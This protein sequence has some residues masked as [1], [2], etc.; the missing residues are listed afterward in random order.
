MGVSFEF[1]VVSDSEKQAQKWLDFAIEETK[2]VED[3]ISSWKPTS[4][5]SKINQNAGIKPVKVSK[6]L[7]DLIKRSKEISKLTRGYF[8][9]S[10][11]SI[12]KIWDFQK[13]YTQIPDSLEVK[14]SVSKI[15]YENIILNNEK[16]T[17]FLKEKG[18][19]IGF[20]AIGKGFV[21]EHIKKLWKKQGVSVGLINASGDLTC[22]G[23]PPQSEAWKIGI[24]NPFDKTHD[25]GWF[26]LKDSGVVTSGGYE[27]YVEINGKRYAHIINPKTGWPS[28]GLASVTIFCANAELADALATAV[29][30]MGAE[31]GISFINQLKGVEALLVDNQGVIYKSNDLNLKK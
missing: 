8:D 17:V 3:S 18:M 5:T 10:F 23:V 24:T 26:D 27:K 16:Q 6:E 12:D 31:K 15:N 30:V 9:I 14:K 4:Q 11:A 19:K 25:L 1:S 13:K 7:F 21:A 28:E 2:R 22:F 20:G 29:F